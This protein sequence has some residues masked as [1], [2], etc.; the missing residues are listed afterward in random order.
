MVGSADMNSVYMSASYLIDGSVLVDIPGGVLRELK[1]HGVES[2]EVKQVLITHLHA[3]HTLD[4]PLWILKKTKE[5]PSVGEKGIPVYAGR[6]CCGRLEQI[7]GCSFFTS[8]TAEKIA[9][10][11][12]WRTED[13]F[14]IDHLSFKRI[15]VSHGTLP[16]CCGYMVT[17][18]EMSVGFTG[19]SCL[20]D[21]VRKLASSCDLLFCDCDL[22]TGNE[23]HMGI[24][25]LIKLKEEYPGCRIIATHL[26]DET[27][28][29]LL[30]L[31]DCGIGIAVDGAFYGNEGL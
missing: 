4:L 31:G 10:F 17:D 13:E 23:K 20:C 6:N 29:R 7:T 11:V 3:D 28:A 19:D 16:D 1:R 9:K 18:G 21:G 26:K 12:D 14:A 22:I 25:T 2:S 24:D 27:R 5:V 8:L 30:E 15:P